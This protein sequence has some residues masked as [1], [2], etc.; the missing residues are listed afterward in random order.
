M[1]L[2]ENPA[3]NP[4]H[5]SRPQQRSRR[6]GRKS[7]RKPTAPSPTSV[8]DTEGF[9][10]TTPRLQAALPPWAEAAEERGE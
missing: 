4:S 2:V 9:D 6:R 8:Y 7:S 5:R 10:A 3:G 1:G